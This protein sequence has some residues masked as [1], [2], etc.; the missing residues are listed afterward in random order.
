MAEIN[1][2]HRS[3][4]TTRALEILNIKPL[5]ALQSLYEAGQ[6]DKVCLRFFLFSRNLSFTDFFFIDIF[7][8][9]DL[10]KDRLRDRTR[11]WFLNPHE[12]KD[13][14]KI[15]HEAY[16]YL[17][18]QFVDDVA[19]NTVANKGISTLLSVE[20][21]NLKFSQGELW[22]SLYI[23]SDK[24]HDGDAVITEEN[25]SQETREGLKDMENKISVLKSMDPNLNVNDVLPTC[26]KMDEML[27]MQIIP[28]KKLSKSA[29]ES[30]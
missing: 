28:K 4:V 10:L 17:S 23:K 3:P 11:Q 13:N 30:R 25:T 20:A 21:I 16:Q 7:Q 9:I 12:N 5:T 18:K 27:T 22:S 1:N 26:F 19:Q 8:I 15:I 2:N 29:S 24:I 6:Y 14:M